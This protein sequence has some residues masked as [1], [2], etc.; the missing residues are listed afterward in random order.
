MQIYPAQWSQFVSLEGQISTKVEG[1]KKTKQGL[2]IYCWEN[3]AHLKN[4]I[5]YY[6]LSLG[7]Y[8]LCS[9]EMF[10][11]L[12]DRPLLPDLGKPFLLLNLHAYLNHVIVDGH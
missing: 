5:D 9:S 4:L 1:Q 2:L 3:L 7:N 11:V 8:S 10:T 6:H 12:S